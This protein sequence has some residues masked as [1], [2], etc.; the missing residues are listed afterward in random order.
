MSKQHLREEL[1]REVTL[2]YHYRDG[3]EHTTMGE[4]KTGSGGND[5]QKQ[6]NKAAC[7]MV[8]ACANELLSAQ[9]TRDDT[10]KKELDTLSRAAALKC[11]NVQFK[12][13]YGAFLSDQRLKSE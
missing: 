13:R 11:A 9:L 4:G 2:A 6:L 3:F 12:S 7:A 8:S 5:L 1:S 10:E